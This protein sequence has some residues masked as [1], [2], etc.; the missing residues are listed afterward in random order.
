MSVKKLSIF[1]IIW[2]KPNKVKGRRGMRKVLG[3]ITLLLLMSILSCPYV[4]QPMECAIE[5][6][7]IIE[8]Q[9]KNDIT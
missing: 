4:R 2:L 5:D 9:K 7:G 6:D 1:Y 8:W 3:L